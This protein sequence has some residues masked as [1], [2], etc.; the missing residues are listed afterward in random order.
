MSEPDD[1]FGE[2][3]T[4]SME[5]APK[6]IIR[7]P[8]GYPGGKSRV[9]EKILPHLP[10]DKGYITVFGGSGCDLLARNVSLLEVYNDRFGGVTAFFR[11]L[12]DQ[13]DAL[14]QRLELCLHSREEFEWC[15]ETWEGV[16][17]ELERAARWYY[18]VQM[19]FSQLG[20]N[21]GRAVRN[22]GH[23]GT[24]WFNALEL[25]VPISQRLRNVQIENLDFRDCIREFDD[26]HNVF[27]DDPPYL[28][29]NNGSIYKGLVWT[30]TDQIQLC[31]LIH[32]SQGFHCLCGY[33]NGVCDAINDRYEWDHRI[34]YESLTTVGAQVGTE[35]NNLAG[36]IVERGMSKEVLWIKEA[37]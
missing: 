27:F 33:A 26:P 24:K 22:R 16:N 12:R 32:D 31:E 34:E 29:T 37:R 19:S 18:M 17:D 4:H 7:A 5:T 2:L 13:P 8:F 1:L 15:R 10:Y 3:D 21:F 6:E 25:F 28:G 30:T 14:I 11:V 23:F 20:R 36:R 9:L 35:T